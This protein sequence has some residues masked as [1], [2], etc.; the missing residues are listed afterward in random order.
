MDVLVCLHEVSYQWEVYLRLPLLVGCSQQCLL[1][2]HIPGFFPIYAERMIWSLC[3]IIVILTF[4]SFILLHL[5]SVLAGV[6]LVMTYLSSLLVITVF[7]S[8]LPLRER[9]NSLTPSG[10]S[11]PSSGGELESEGPLGQVG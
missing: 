10:K 2:N 4:F 8:K 9:L 3:L 1:S 5:S 6:H 11:T 7:Y